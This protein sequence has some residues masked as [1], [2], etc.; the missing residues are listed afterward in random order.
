MRI[1]SQ[2]KTE[3]IPYEMS[4]MYISEVHTGTI[5]AE[6]SGIS[7]TTML[8][9]YYTNEDAKTALQSVRMAYFSGKKYWL[10]PTVDE[11]ARERLARE[12]KSNS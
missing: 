8:G 10:M 4:R 5:K 9:D 11:V 1:I 12:Q 3:D 2:D 7:D 6:I